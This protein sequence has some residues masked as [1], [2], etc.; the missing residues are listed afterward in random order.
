MKFF[1]FSS[2]I[3]L[4]GSSQM[5]HQ[6]EYGY[7]MNPDALYKLAE[8]INGKVIFYEKLLEKMSAENSSNKNKNVDPN[9]KQ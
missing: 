1:E 5:W 2:L 9:L 7:L 8:Q 3:F 6:N 4:M